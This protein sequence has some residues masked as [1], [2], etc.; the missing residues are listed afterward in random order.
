MEFSNSRCLR[1]LILLTDEIT[2]SP[3]LIRPG[4]ERRTRIKSG[5]P[6]KSFQVA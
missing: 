2:L 6:Q 1:P 5:L 4:S 3:E